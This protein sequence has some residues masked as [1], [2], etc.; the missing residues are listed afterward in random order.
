MDT[1]QFYIIITPGSLKFLEFALWS[2][3]SR[4]DLKITL[5]AN[6]LNK[7]EDTE[8]KLFCDQI[9]CDYISLNTNRVYS[10]GASLNALI[11][12]HDETWF[13]FCDSDILSLD[14]KANDI[15]IAHQYKA[16]SACDA[17]FWDDNEV[18]G[19]LGRCNRWPDGSPNLSSFFCIYHTETIKYLMHKYKIN[20]DNT[21]YSQIT[22]D[23]ISQILNQKGL[24]KNRHK[25]DT[26]KVITAALE[27]DNHLFSHIE[28]PS[29]LHIGGMSSWML[30]GDKKLIYTQ[31]HLTDKDLY[32]LAHEGSWLF[33]KNAQTDKNN[34]IFYLRRQQRL[35]AA[36]YCFQ[37]I[38]HY[39]DNTP[40]P[41]HSL[42][43]VSFNSKINHIEDIIQ[44]YQ[45]IV[46]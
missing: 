30:N 35:S 7:E 21:E 40:K 3:Q 24:D 12:Q 22:S 1:F 20:F 6:G 23:T 17:M 11:S 43:D 32:D 38:S 8:L 19:V 15:Q 9:Q 28:I 31:Y 46:S 10:H 27:M 25:L 33:N 42:S 5:V 36:R 18:K 4:Q 29:L 39:V 13:C 37:L 44:Q 45:N 34:K 16:L 26:G 2:L 41:T 14:P